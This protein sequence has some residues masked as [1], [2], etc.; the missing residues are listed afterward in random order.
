MSRTVTDPIIGHVPF[1]DGFERA[2]HQ[3]S[4]GRMYVID[5]VGLRVFGVWVLGGDA[6]DAM[7]ITVSRR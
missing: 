4:D 3:T 5:G 7:P 2:V 6:G 1:T